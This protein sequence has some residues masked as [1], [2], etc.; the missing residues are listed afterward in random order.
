MMREILP[1]L[2]SPSPSPE[3]EDRLIG[4]EARVFA[5]KWAPEATGLIEVVRG[6]GTLRAVEIRIHANQPGPR[7][8]VAFHQQW[9]LIKGGEK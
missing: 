1:I 2:L 4:L 6:T 9:E 8:R 3:E 7:I 5:D